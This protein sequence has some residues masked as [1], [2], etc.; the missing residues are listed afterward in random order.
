MAVAVLVFVAMNDL[1]FAGEMRSSSE[2]ATVDVGLN[3]YDAFITEAS[4]RF[5]IPP[6]W[7]RAIM[8]A[9]ST[10]DVRAVSDKGALGL[11]QV[12]PETYAELRARHHLGADMFD[13]RD[14]ILAG[15]AYM[16]EMR[17]RFGAPGF[18][19]A[20]HAGPARYDD[21]LTNGRPL[22]EETRRY[23]ADLTPRIGAPEPEFAS[24][25]ES[26]PPSWANAPLFV[27]RDG[28]QTSADRT[29]VVLLTSDRSAKTR[30][31]SELQSYRRPTT[32]KSPVHARSNGL[33]VTRSNPGT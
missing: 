5:D 12:M 30:T 24:V 7:I 25:A 13:P 23:V 4:R 14:N 29:S 21:Y 18:L 16:R 2:R 9:E 20:Y 33:F 6:L 32:S 26:E 1:S 31:S 19:A 27:R 17:D 28:D 10:G 3:G 11:M 22:P 8:R 15:T